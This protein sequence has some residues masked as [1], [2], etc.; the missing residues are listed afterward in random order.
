[1]LEKKF[2]RQGLLDFAYKDT[3]WYQKI[4]DESRH[5]RYHLIL[6]AL[7]TALAFPPFL[8]AS[9]F[10]NKRYDLMPSQPVVHL[11]FFLILSVLLAFLIRFRRLRLMTYVSLALP[12]IGFFGSVYSPG[13]SGLYMMISLV[14]PALA[15]QLR[16]SRRG[17]YWC[18]GYFGLVS[19]VGFLQASS[20]LPPWL[21]SPTFELS[22]VSFLTYALIWVFSYASEKRQEGMISRLTDMIVFDESTGLPCRD[23]LLH[24]LKK[25]RFYVFAIIKIENFS[26][27]VALF[28]YEFSDI[29]SQF[30]SRKLRKYENRYRYRTYQLKYN[31][32]GILIDSD[33][34]PT[35]QGAEQLLS[36]I[37]KSLDLESLPW[38]RDRI[39]LVYRLGAAIVLP[40]DE[41]SP[42]S[43]SDI[44][45]K[46]AERTHS[47]LSVF[48]EDESEKTTAYES[49]IRFSELINNRETEGFRAVFQP[50]FCDK[51]AEVVWYE[52]LLRLRR[53]DGSYVSIHPYLEVAKSTGLYPYL[54]DFILRASADAIVRNDVD[55]SVN[56]AIHD[57]MRPEFILLVDEVFEIIKEKKGR[58]IFEILESDELVELDR[59]L[60]FIEYI[61]CYGFKIAIDDFGTGYSN[62]CTLIN[63]PVDIVKID[64]SLIRKIR[65]DDNARTLVEGIVHFCRKSNKKTVAE[66][67]EDELVFDSLRSMHIDYLQGYYLAEPAALA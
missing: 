57:I 8:S 35:V 16:G 58:I 43:R 4:R 54:T 26:D 48:D 49:V 36:K 22:A 27:L 45:L 11:A 3:A 47:V 13:G 33:V 67:V 7:S 64:G 59:C 62:Y 50:I 23:V 52:A 44:A 24:S 14:Y 9:L 32:Y 28:G 15:I 39:R 18:A 21:I 30:A 25:N 40:G 60:C 42:L 41:R 65:T 17:S 31:E 10:F 29:I 1:M 5:Y 61:T 38:E 6:Y 56:I 34:E 63:L 20:V 53:Q 12:V 55:V 19:A 51:G 66:F 2:I 37:V 46:K